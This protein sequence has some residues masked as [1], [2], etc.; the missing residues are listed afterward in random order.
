MLGD[1]F[2]PSS[3]SSCRWSRAS[4]PKRP[5]SVDTTSDCNNRFRRPQLLAKSAMTRV[6]L[7]ATDERDTMLKGQSGD[8]VPGALRC[9]ER[10]RRRQ[11]K[12]PTWRA[13]SHALAYGESISH[14]PLPIDVKCHHANRWRSCQILGVS[15]YI[16]N[17]Q[18]HV[19]KHILLHS[20][21]DAGDDH[22]IAYSISCTSSWTE[23]MHIRTG[24]T[25]ETSSIHNAC[26]A[27]R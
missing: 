19:L 12:G 7:R 22:V 6:L 26:Q 5:S 11:R 2:D 9:D 17:V 25:V 4:S 18:E 20:R 13:P 14:N 23:G 21:E 3:Y 10:A 24:K 8:K 15:T 1:G 16:S 27:N